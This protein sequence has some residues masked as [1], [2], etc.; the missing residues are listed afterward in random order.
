[1]HT[2][3]LLRSRNVDTDIDSSKITYMHVNT[4]KT[5]RSTFKMEK[6]TINWFKL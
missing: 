3:V 5:G 4:E 2:E 6:Y 1:M